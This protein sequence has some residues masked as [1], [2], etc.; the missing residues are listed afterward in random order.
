VADLAPVGSG[1]TLPQFGWRGEAL[2]L[3]LAAGDVV[4]LDDAVTVGRVG[5]L[6]SEH[7]GGFAGLLHAG[8]DG[9]ANGL[10]FDDGERVVAPVVQE[11]VG[12]PLLAAANPTAGDDDPS[13]GEAALFANGVRFGRP[14]GFDE[15]RG[16]IF[17]AGVRFG[18]RG[19]KTSL[20]QCDT[21]AASTLTMDMID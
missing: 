13:V 4:D 8:F 17:A 16:D 15:P 18:Q 14:A 1:Q 19:I 9:Q 2:D 11:V 6:Q 3:A 21:S 20:Y 5:K 7:L 12:T 10:R